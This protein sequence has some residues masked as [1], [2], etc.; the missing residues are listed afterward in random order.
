M[1][2]GLQKKGATSKK[3]FWDCH[4][5]FFYLQSNCVCVFMEIIQNMMKLSA[6]LVKILP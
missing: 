1:L 5:P 3:K 2:E 4:A 6:Y